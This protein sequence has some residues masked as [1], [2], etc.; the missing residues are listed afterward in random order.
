MGRF[1]G[2]FS[3]TIMKRKRLFEISENLQIS[4]LQKINSLIL[5][6]YYKIY[7]IF[8]FNNITNECSVNNIRE[9]INRIVLVKLVIEKCLNTFLQAHFKC[10]LIRRGSRKLLYFIKL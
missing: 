7:M 6:L 10:N 4:E 1:I 9:Y 8:L 2:V 5:I 3:Q